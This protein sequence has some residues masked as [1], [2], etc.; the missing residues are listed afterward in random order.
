MNQGTGQAHLTPRGQAVCGPRPPDHGGSGGDPGGDTV[1]DTVGGLS[2]GGCGRSGLR[3]SLV[4]GSTVEGRPHA[5][6]GPESSGP[7][8]KS[9]QVPS[10]LHAPAVALSPFARSYRKPTDAM[11]FV[12]LGRIWAGPREASHCAG[13]RCLSPCFSSCSPAPLLFIPSRILYPSPLSNKTASPFHPQRTLGIIT[14]FLS[15][16]AESHICF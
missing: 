12:G 7:S 3:K 4:T 14:C 15:R 11:C 10:P 16:L 13:S 6:A 9:V 8:E 1:G 5:C 2:C